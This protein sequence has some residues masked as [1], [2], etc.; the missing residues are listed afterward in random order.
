MEPE[1]NRDPRAG[2]VCPKRICRMVIGDDGYR[3]RAGESA[4]VLA[5]QGDNA[6]KLKEDKYINR[7]R[8]CQGVDRFERTRSLVL[9]E[10]RLRECNSRTYR[11]DK[12]RKDYRLFWESFRE[13]IGTPPT[14]SPSTLE[15]LVRR[16]FEAEGPS[17]VAE[18]PRFVAEETRPPNEGIS[19]YTSVFALRGQPYSASPYAATASTYSGTQSSIPGIVIP[20]D[21]EPSSDEAED[22][23]QSQAS[24]ED[25]AAIDPSLYSELST[26]VF[27]HGDQSQ[28]SYED[29]TAAGESESE[30]ANST[31]TIFSDMEPPDVIR[32][33]M[34]SDSNETAHEVL[35]RDASLL[36]RRV[37]DP[38]K[39]MRKDPNRRKYERIGFN[40]ANV[41][42]YQVKSEHLVRDRDDP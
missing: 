12:T 15:A 13:E 35:T 24:Y 5:E 10:Q 4:R 11:I 21:P 41:A 30:D 33:N 6:P 27:E 23:P 39:L 34:F 20:A 25:S 32:Y 9:K 31:L 38:H 19:R 8:V 14:T 1:S 18:E 29:S 28:E 17:F 2:T 22:E 7:C 36:R 42:V 40:R 16:R 37:A 26:D 3:L